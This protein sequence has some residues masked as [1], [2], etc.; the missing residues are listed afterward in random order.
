M[1]CKFYGSDGR[2]A[3]MSRRRA[4]DF[5]RLGE[6]V[7]PASLAPADPLYDPPTLEGSPNLVADPA[8]ALDAAIADAAREA[9]DNAVEGMIRESLEAG[10]GEAIVVPDLPPPGD[11]ANP[12]PEP[13]LPWYQPAID[14]WR[15]LVPEDAAVIPPGAFR[16]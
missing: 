12:A 9:A 11:P 7:A 13:E 5:D 10:A 8:G 6:R 1:T 2:A 15:Y 4:L 3:R 16:S 14:V